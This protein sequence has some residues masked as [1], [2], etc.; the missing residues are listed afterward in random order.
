MYLGDGYIR[1][2]P[3][4][5]VLRVYLHV[6]QRDVAERVSR[7]ISTLLPYNRVSL[8]RR[9]DAR[10]VVVTC[11]SQSWPALF[12]QHGPGRKHRR[13]IVL[14]PWQQ[15]VITRHPEEF[16][17]GLIESDGCR[18]RRIVAGRNYP[19]YSFSNRSED[20]RQLFISACRLTGLHPRPANRFTISIARRADVARLDAIMGRPVEPGPFLLAR[21]ASARGYGDRSYVGRGLPNL[22]C[23]IPNTSCRPSSTE[24]RERHQ[25]GA[26]KGSCGVGWT[27][28]GIVAW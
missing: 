20:I 1:R 17:R 6:D 13:R 22:K 11:Y 26:S 10:V 24:R 23:R 2:C 12:P 19:A 8:G 4:S 15:D 7:A 25:R 28:A 5:Y 27:S 21:E 9:H 3:K 18:H 14:E 16:L